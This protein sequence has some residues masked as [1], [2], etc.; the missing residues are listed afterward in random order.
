MKQPMVHSSWRHGLLMEPFREST[1]T[2]M[3]M[4]MLKSLNMVLMPWDSSQKEICLK[5]SLFHH[6]LK[7]T[8]LTVA[9][10]MTTQT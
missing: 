9:M 1:A 5:E 7:E 8:A 6:Q 2:L 3:P 4:G 10:T